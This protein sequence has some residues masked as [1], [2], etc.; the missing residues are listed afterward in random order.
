[1][2]TSHGGLTYLPDLLNIS[3]STS[4]GHHQHLTSSCSDSHSP[5]RSGSPPHLSSLP[6]PGIETFTQDGSVIHVS[7]VHQV[8]MKFPLDFSNAVHCPTMLKTREPNPLLFH[9]ETFQDFLTPLTSLPSWS[10]PPSDPG[11]PPPILQV[12]PPSSH[13]PSNL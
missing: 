6:L 3:C 9:H 12:R 1:M 11:P 10:P 2:G 5:S 13:P 7:E 4:S 8:F